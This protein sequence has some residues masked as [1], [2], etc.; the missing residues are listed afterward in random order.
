MDY[1]E[2][3][4]KCRYLDDSVIQQIMSALSNKMLEISLGIIPLKQISTL[5]KSSLLI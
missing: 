4:M 3:I 5:R 2:A 1:R